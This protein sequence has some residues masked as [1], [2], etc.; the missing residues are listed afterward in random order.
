MA[1][2]VPQQSIV[3][4]LVVAVAECLRIPAEQVD[5]HSSFRR[6]GLDSLTAGSLAS[7]LSTWLERPVPITLLWEFPSVAELAAHLA[8]APRPAAAP[9]A[10]RV[11]AHEP[12]A[13]VGIACRFPGADSPAAFWELLRSGTDAITDIP[14]DR[15]D[16]DALHAP[17]PAT[18][19]T[20]PMRQGG[21][22]RDVSGFD[23]HFFGISPRE[24]LHMDPQQ[25]I[26]L[27]LSWEALEDAGIPPLSLAGSATGVFVGAIWSDF[28]LLLGRLGL[29]AIAPH[30]VTGVH[31]SIIANRVSYT[32]GL[33]GPSMAID[34]ACSA[35]LVA[36]HLGCESLRSGESTLAL[37][38]GVNLI[39]A[40]D[41]LVQMAKFGAT[42]PGGRCR[43]F[44]A[45]GDGYAR[46]EGA[47]LVVL[48][49]LSRAIADGNPIHCV[50]RGSATNNDGRS[51]G[52]TAP[53]PRAQRSLLAMA[54]QRAGVDP[55]SVDYVEAH[56][57]GTKLGDP[58]EAS[59]IGAVYGKG[60]PPERPLR[61]GSVKSNIG[62]AEAAAGIA[63]LIKVAL[64]LRHHELPASLHFGTPNPQIDFASLGIEVQAR[65]G[66]WPEREGPARAGVSSFGFGG[67][68]AHVVLEA[69]RASE[70]PAWPVAAPNP[71]SRAPRQPVFY[72]AGHGS[73]WLGMARELLVASPLFRARLAACDRAIQAEVGWSLL[74]ELFAPP[75]ASRLN[76]PDVVQPAIFAVQVALAELWRSWGV[77]P[78]AVLGH[79]LGEVAAAHVAGALTL[80]D[81]VRLVC[82]RGKLTR[83]LAGQ[84]GLLLVERSRHELAAAIHGMEGVTLA[85][86]NAPTSTALSGERAA[87]ERLAAEQR[88]AGVR[89]AFVDIAFPSHSP[90]VD[91]ILGELLAGLSE[92]SPQ[93][94]HIPLLSTV[95]GRFVEGRDLDARY[96]VRN[97]REP[98]DFAGAV[99][100]LAQRGEDLFLEVGPQP[101]LV[102]FVEQCLAHAGRPGRVVASVHR[103]APEG[104]A[105][106]EAA[107]TLQE[108][109]VPVRPHLRDV[110]GAEAPALP[111]VLP[112]S[113]H[114]PEALRVRVAGLLSRLGTQPDLDLDDLCYTAACGRSHLGHRVAVVGS[115]RA[116]LREQLVAAL[117]HPLGA[118]LS[119]TEPPRLAFVFPGQG[120]QWEG[121]G[122]ELLEQEPAFR[123][124][125]LSCDAALAPYLGGSIAARLSEGKAIEDRADVAQP[126]LF[127][128]Q[129]ALCRLWESLG[130]RAAAVVGHSMGEVAAAHVAGAL[131]LEDAARVICARSRHLRSLHGRG[132][133][134]IVE[135][136]PDELAAA[137]ARWSGRASVA[138]RNGPRSFAL[139]GEREAVE[140]LVAEVQA[141]GA[142][143]RVMG[144]EFPMSH[145]PQV[146]PVQGALA[147]DLAG[148]TPRRAA[149]PLYSTTTGLVAEGPELDTRHWV[150]NVREPVHFHEQV[151][152]LL[153]DGVRLLLEVGPHPLLGHACEQT[154]AE[155]GVSAVILHS[156]RRGEGQRYLYE[157]L[158]QLYTCGVE[159]DWHAVQRRG[160][161][162]LPLPAYPWQRKPYW[163]E[164]LSGTTLPKPEINAAPAPEVPELS[165]L[166]QAVR[167]AQGAPEPALVEQILRLRASAILQLPASM[168][169][170]ESSLKRLGLDSIM[171]MQLNNRLRALLQVDVPVSLLLED[172]ALRALAQGL[173]AHVREA[174]KPVIDAEA[175]AAQLEEGSL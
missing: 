102:R 52:L 149:L 22:L 161:R 168:L 84:G 49:P 29:S 45:G 98:V 55:T 36:V 95:T 41:S 170:P 101:A 64:S 94:T 47:G 78:R 144:P 83:R 18:P 156:L 137:L 109:G 62:H 162:F 164:G 174:R 143:A 74:Q 157:A 51:N 42:S 113:A 24:A 48:K 50:L 7:R 132:T 130:V 9:E 30:T 20:I 122:R 17:D 86:F 23:A 71:S 103:R 65:P 15:F 14:R 32:L 171:A 154:V 16:V 53:S 119:P 35:S 38:G 4:W 26:M 89:C 138:A 139:A 75:E 90:L 148:V 123:H 61:I 134:A 125:L 13:V 39:L 128:F 169:P 57:T 126:A 110:P 116:G 88:A 21:F 72:F 37:A 115:T 92:I 73:Q 127:A 175:L 118:R 150:R 131:S 105:L 1:F 25:R 67:A 34:T 99:D 147:R 28:A 12:I 104:E 69:W 107:A 160:G 135:S 166:E 155:E 85:V 121:M 19:G 117:S 91:P 56:G 111:R 40:P 173:C 43:P 31:H 167:D 60:R 66:P 81:A 124:A 146:E 133:M 97:L 108:Q 63:G 54:C 77:V 10:P 79:S 11:A 46:A 33:E 70:R 140:A 8:G 112:V 120:G 93:P 129:V 80:E 6:L 159:V 172:R 141:Q 82:L 59:A 142:F 106:L 165:R 163:P 68:N 3:R 44:D 152:A 145:C 158:A 5:V 114:T 76:E 136:S 2:G 100:L 58:I 27:E 96:W 153:R 87:L 151:R